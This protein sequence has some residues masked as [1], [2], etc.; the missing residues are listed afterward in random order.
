MKSKVPLF[1]DHHHLRKDQYRD[2]SNLGS[3]ISLHEAFSVNPVPWQKWIFSQ[4]DLPNEADILE[5]GCGSGNLWVENEPFDGEMWSLLL[6]DLSLG[7]VRETIGSVQHWRYVLGAVADAASLPLC[8]DRFDAV[9]ANHM[10]FHVK[11]PTQALSEIHRVLRPGGILHATTVGREH[12]LELREVLLLAKD[13]RVDVMEDESAQV[14]ASF[15]LQAGMEKVQD[16]FRDVE[17]RVFDDWL[18]ITDAEPLIEYVLSSSVWDLKEEGIMRLRDIVEK[19]IE[20]AGS[21]KVRKHQ[22]MIIA[23]K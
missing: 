18:E 1:T 4:I 8:H 22:G 23:R 6:T 20:N 21:F 9:I 13:I 2:S 10:L 3:R 14:L 5:L 7:M 17:V 16:Q 11:N 12:L 19:R 15:T